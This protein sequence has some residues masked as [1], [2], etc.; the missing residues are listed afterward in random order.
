MGALLYHKSQ[1]LDQ[2]D[3]PRLPIEYS[4]AR[5]MG[6]SEVTFHITIGPSSYIS[7]MN[8]LKIHSR[9]KLRNWQFVSKFQV[10]SS[11]HHNTASL[12]H[13]P[14]CCCHGSLS[15][16]QRRL[17][18]RRRLCGLARTPLLSSSSR[19]SRFDTR[20]WSTAKCECHVRQA[21]PCNP[22]TPLFACREHASLHTTQP[23]VDRQCVCVCVLA[24]AGR[25]VVIRR[26]GR[27]L[28]KGLIFCGP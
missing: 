26:R 12:Q 17:P 28:S 13:Q 5:E 21:A 27:L 1:G 22:R 8:V 10:P 14:T 19:A 16:S 20:C 25:G 18:R 3:A 2:C 6:R 23:A 15:R 24:R 4:Q 9:S 7:K 11:P